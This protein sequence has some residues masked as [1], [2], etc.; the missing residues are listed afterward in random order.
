[1][2]QFCVN[3]SAARDARIG[4]MVS[5]YNIYIMYVFIVLSVLLSEL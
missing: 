3:P 5:I 4:A 2:K 1:M